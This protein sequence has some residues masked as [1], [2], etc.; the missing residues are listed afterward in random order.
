MISKHTHTHTETLIG[1]SKLCAHFYNV[2]NISMIICFLN[3]TFDEILII[4]QR[5]IEVSHYLSDQQQKNFLFLSTGKQRAE[6]S[7]QQQQYIHHKHC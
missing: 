7:P 6:N 1:Y 3:C 4:T 2:I 5:R